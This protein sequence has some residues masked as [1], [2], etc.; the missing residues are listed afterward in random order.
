MRLKPA[1]IAFALAASIAAVKAQG[2]PDDIASRIINDPGAP[3][4]TG[5]SAKLRDD[6]GVQGGRALRIQVAGKGANAWD[7]AVG[8]A[9]QKPVRTGDRLVLAFWARLAKGEGGLA[10]ATLPYNAVQLASAPYSPLFSGPATI[11]P[12]WKLYE[13]RGKSDRDYA[14]GALNAT[15][16]L[17]TGKQTVDIGPVIVLDLG[18]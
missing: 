13:V 14:A 3:Q 8:S 15:L 7:V 6:P 1:L 9:I 5:A 11:G 4:V 18:Q 10:T 2:A 17:A 12:E 16:H